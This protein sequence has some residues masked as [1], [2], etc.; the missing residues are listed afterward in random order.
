MGQSRN[1]LLICG[2]G[3]T[4]H[5]ISL[6]SAK[7]FESKLALIPDIN[8]VYLCIERD[9]RR[10]NKIGQQCE[11]R[12]AGEV[13]NKETQ[14]TI[15]LDYAIPCIHGPPGENG[16][17]QAVFELMGLPYLGAN[18]E[19]S[20][21]CFNK[22]MTKL[23]LDKLRVENSPYTFARELNPQTLQDFEEFFEKNNQDIYIKATH[24]GSSV[25][26]Y[27]ILK[28]ELIKEKMSEALKLSP[29][30]LA[31]RTSRGREL[32]VAAFDYQGELHISS[33][34]EIV[35]PEGFYTFEEKYN[36]DS[37]TVTNIEAKGIDQEI[38]DKIREMARVAF[39]G[40]GLKDLARIDFF[41][42]EDN[43]PLIN[44]IN[45]FPGHTPISMFPMMME[46]LGIKYEDYLKNR[47]FKN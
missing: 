38:Q 42:T 37:K 26:C 32:E 18:P 19:A 40:L 20:I 30:V 13:F 25:G 1:V 41:L 31:E 17:I 6:I 24:Q 45:T 43:V 35:C 10:T 7:Y 2:G 23:W 8:T 22:V 46:N 44:E 33:P 28:K 27:H 21:S 15:A 39:I 9:G 4:E 3:G 12:K 16:H 14:E 5:D 11:L 47:I 34:G 36:P 29:I